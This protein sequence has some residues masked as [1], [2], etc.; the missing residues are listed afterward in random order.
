MNWQAFLDEV[1]A[2]TRRLDRAGAAEI[3]LI[4][5][6]S[7]WAA[8]VHLFAI[9]RSGRT[10]L[11]ADP[12]H[13]ERQGS[14]LAD[15]VSSARRGPCAAPLATT[16]F[17]IGLTSGSTGMPKA[18]RRSHRSWVES[19]DLAVAAF[20]LAPKTRVFVPGGIGH[21]LHLFGAVMALHCG[22][23]L[24]MA[25]HFQ[26]K[27]LARR[28]HEAASTALVVTPTQLQMLAGA[29]ESEGIVLPEMRQILLSGA[30]WQGRAQHALRRVFPNAAMHEFYGTSETSFISHRRSG[31]PEGSVGRPFPGVEVTIRDA[32]G[33]VLNAGA[34]GDIWV[35]S[36]L[37]FDGY[38][39]G[40]EPLTR[41]DGDWVTVGDR[42]HLD[43]NGVLW[44]RGRQ[45]RMLVTSGINVFAEEVETVLARHPGV[46]H[47]AV[48]GVSDTLRGK[49]IV[50]ALAVSERGPDIKVLRRYCL[51]E[52]EAAK[53]P[54]AFHVLDDWPLTPGGKPDLPAIEAEILR[55]EEG[56]AGLS[57]RAEA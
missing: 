19:F 34:E 41:R 45:G 57:R 50:A 55:R 1:D 43:G 31:D 17:Y 44:L 11:V 18:F 32:D 20:A 29:A 23:R 28:M 22:F 47:V 33:R 8:L 46:A 10:A 56:D 49:R 53:V 9:A 27:A 42:G 21:S 26:P 12:V 40:E 24:D 25:R 5:A 16:P 3:V 15:L 14:R 13:V 4:E 6:A 51:S 2:D 38:V 48:F 7:P 54:R 35:R 36:R 37:T 39:I 52:L 30:K